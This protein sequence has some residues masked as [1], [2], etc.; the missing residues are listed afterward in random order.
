M[1]PASRSDPQAL[2][3][4]GNAAY[5]RGAWANAVASYT[6]AIDLWME[7]ADRA[8]LYTNRSAARLKMAGEKQ[9]ALADAERATQLQPSYAKAHFRLA[10]ALRALGKPADAAAALGKVLE[11]SPG[12]AA[13]AADLAEVNKALQGPTK[14]SLAG[15]MLGGAARVA[16]GTSVPSPFSASKPAPVDPAHLPFVPADPQAGQAGAARTGAQEAFFENAA[17]NLQNYEA[18]KP[19]PLPKEPDNTYMGIL[20]PPGY[21]PNAPGWD[22]TYKSGSMFGDEAGEGDPAAAPAAPL[23]A[24]EALAGVE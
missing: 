19:K 20:M 17:I 5:S 2:K 9:K 21:G 24:E 7:P 18:A 8:V 22:P 12:D 11:L 13:A 10:Q 23:S 6:A 16:Q 3:K 1:P 15:A 14:P 4:E